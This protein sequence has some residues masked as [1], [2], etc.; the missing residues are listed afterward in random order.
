MRL[1]FF[2]FFFTIL[3][4]AILSAQGAGDVLKYSFYPNYGTARNMAVSNSMQ[5][6]GGDFSA[7]NSN[8]GGIGIFRTSEFSITP[9]LKF[10]RTKA[11]HYGSNTIKP[12]SKLNIDHAGYLSTSKRG[13]SFGVLFASIGFGYNRI[14]DFNNEYEISGPVTQSSWLD[15][16][17]QDLIKSNLTPSQI[18]ESAGL[19]TETY[20]AWQT[21][22][23]D[24]INGTGKYFHSNEGRE[25]TQTRSVKTTGGINSYYISYGQNINNRLY[26][27]VI[28]EMVTLNYN[29]VLT[30]KEV[31]PEKRQVTDLQEFTYI[32]NLKTT[33]TGF[34]LK[35]GAIYRVNDIVRM[36]LAYHSPTSFT[37]N[38]AW[39]QTLSSKID[40]LNP[41]TASSP[42]Q[43]YANRYSLYTPSRLNA[44]LAFIIGKRGFISSSVEY[45]DYSSSKLSSRTTGGNFDDANNTIK[46]IYQG[47]YTFNVGGE[48]R[49]NHFALRTGYSH[50]TDPYTNSSGNSSPQH[51]F[52]LGGG[53]RSGNFYLDCAW[54]GT[55]FSEKAWMY[56]SF[57]ISPSKLNSIHQ[58]ISITAGL[59]WK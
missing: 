32:Q 10:N 17:Y 26:W 20:L 19:R 34:K 57:Y 23:L 49:I 11:S 53:Y 27:G 9:S 36:G 29:E 24:T 1:K 46:R 7:I 13:N 51:S 2:V 28:G 50:K 15:V 8:P 38:D 16:L 42:E 25:G 12:S 56:D 22:L 6:L 40:N 59:R 39:D 35:L 31:M 48:Y 14:A 4:P 41:S 5:A 21:F 45:T 30:Y 43:G 44:S 33:G 52:S 54:R 18:N 58:L 37:V 3:T 47:G 55:F